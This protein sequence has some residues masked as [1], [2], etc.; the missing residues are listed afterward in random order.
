MMI[1]WHNE[2]T[3]SFDHRSFDHR[4]LECRYHRLHLSAPSYR[5]RD[6]ESGAQFLRS[7]THRRQ[8][9]MAIHLVRDHV[10]MREAAPVVRHPKGDRGVLEAELGVNFLRLGVT[11]G[12]GNGLLSDSK[13]L[14]LHLGRA[15]A[16]R[17]RDSCRETHWLRG[18]RTLS[19]VL[20]RGDEVVGLQRRRAQVPNR[21]TRLTNISL[22]VPPDS[23]ELSFGG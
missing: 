4:R 16:W 10:A 18:R 2:P 17:A 15:S 9:V 6:P 14:V 7:F 11:D 1:D 12:V 23:Q 21:L 22:D 13:Q 8:A 20:Q 3:K 19:E 5:C